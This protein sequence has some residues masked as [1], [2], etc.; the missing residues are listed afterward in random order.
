MEYKSNVQKKLERKNAKAIDYKFLTPVTDYV[1]K[2]YGDIEEEL[3]REDYVEIVNEIQDKFSLVIK[4]EDNS[5]TLANN[6][7]S[8]RNYS[9]YSKYDT[10]TTKEQGDAEPIKFS[11][12]TLNI[13][14]II[15]A[16]T[17]N[18]YSVSCNI[19]IEKLYYI[20]DYDKYANY[21]LDIITK[22]KAE[23]IKKAEER[24]KL[25]S[26]SLTSTFKDIK[27]FGIVLDIPKLKEERIARELEDPKTKGARIKEILED[28]V[29]D[30]RDEYGW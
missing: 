25:E 27:E 6:S 24:C 5:L 13:N 28:Q 16:N 19:E 2:V 11:V 23:A 14:S 26:E 29:E 7:R 10:T 18:D 12:S 8:I 1:T 17:D 4:H 22:D 20:T 30:M 21:I 9:K 15:K 3:T